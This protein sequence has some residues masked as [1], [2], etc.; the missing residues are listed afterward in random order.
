MP[1][2]TEDGSQAAKMERVE[3]SLFL[4]TKQT[5]CF[6]HILKTKILPRKNV[7]APTNLKTWLPA[8]LHLD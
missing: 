4:S 5:V 7:F 3:H 2:H 8:C 6:K 1:R